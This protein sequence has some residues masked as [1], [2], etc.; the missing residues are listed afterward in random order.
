M[1][2]RLCPQ[3]VRRSY[4]LVHPQSHQTLLEGS[5]YMTDA[6]LHSSLYMFPT[7]KRESA[8]MKHQYDSHLKETFSR[9]RW[10]LANPCVFCLWYI[11]LPSSPSWH[12]NLRALYGIWTNRKMMMLEA[13]C[14]RKRTVFDGWTIWILLLICGLSATPC[15]HST[16]LTLYQKN[17]VFLVSFLAQWHW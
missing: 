6:T 11:A 5:L 2:P 17:A 15:K 10:T 12:G 3:S 1:P 7:W 9:S 4:A 14:T 16:Y 13:T 8:S